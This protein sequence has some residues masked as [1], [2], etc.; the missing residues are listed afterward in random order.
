MATLLLAP[1]SLAASLRW[2]IL[3][4]M[5]AAWQRIKAKNVP[6]LPVRERPAG[7]PGQVKGPGLGQGL[8]EPGHIGATV[9]EGPDT[10]AQ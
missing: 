6:S 2:P 8:D 1:H 9:P 10:E 5:H 3:A 4:T 7:L